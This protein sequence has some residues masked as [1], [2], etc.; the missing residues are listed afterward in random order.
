MTRLPVPEAASSALTRPRACTVDPSI[1]LPDTIEKR[2]K[3]EQLARADA[4]AL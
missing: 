1:V 2:R 4:A 3:V